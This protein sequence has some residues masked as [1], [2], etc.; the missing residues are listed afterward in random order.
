MIERPV[1]LKLWDQTCPLR[2]IQGA[3]AGT[4]A[5]EHSR[6]IS[7]LWIGC[8]CYAEEARGAPITSARGRRWHAFQK[9][10]GAMS[11]AFDDDELPP[12]SKPRAA[13]GLA[14][15][16][17]GTNLDGVLVQTVY[18]QHSCSPN[19]QLDVVNQT[20]ASC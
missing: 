15:P 19:L 14:P 17:V 7:A 11:A 8:F 3:A 16:D 20:D 13:K 10:R 1:L 4:F 2:N 5:T 9:M 6:R 18:G 12:A